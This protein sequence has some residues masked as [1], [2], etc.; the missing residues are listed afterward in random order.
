MIH[1]IALSVDVRLTAAY[2][3][4]YCLGFSLVRYLLPLPS[5]SSS[6]S[7]G[8]INGYKWSDPYKFELYQIYI[9]TIQFVLTKTVI[10]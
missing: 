3:P 2:M 9:E 8:D 5:K 6:E 1:V 10:L 4:G 7:V